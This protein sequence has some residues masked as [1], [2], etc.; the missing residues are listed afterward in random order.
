MRAIALAVALTISTAVPAMSSD[1]NMKIFR[2][3]DKVS[4]ANIQILGSSSGYC[5][6][7][8]QLY[9]VSLCGA[10]YF[11][12]Q[13]QLDVMNRYMNADHYWHLFTAGGAEVC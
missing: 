12:C 9:Q 1:Y 7:G 3:S 13:Q 6:G 11:I 2:S 4:V 10:V 8:A 5:E